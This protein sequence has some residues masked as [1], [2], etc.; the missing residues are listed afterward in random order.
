MSK[1]TRGKDLK[2]DFLAGGLFIKFDVAAFVSILV[3]IRRLVEISR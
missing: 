2:K 1:S 3:I